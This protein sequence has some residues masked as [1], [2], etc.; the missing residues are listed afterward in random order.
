VKAWTFAAPAAT[1]STSSET[2]T[3]KKSISSCVFTALSDITFILFLFCPPSIVSALTQVILVVHDKVA[4]ENYLLTL[5]AAS[6]ITANTSFGFESIA[7]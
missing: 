3:S 5:F 2:G 4:S 1:S 6:I 7:T